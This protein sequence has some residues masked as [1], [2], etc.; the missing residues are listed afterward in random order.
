MDTGRHI[1]PEKN[2]FRGLG[3]EGDK[4]MFFA[5]TIPHPLFLAKMFK[6]QNLLAWKPT[7]NVQ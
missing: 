3:A 4:T 2:I 5:S 1:E 6:R 7:E